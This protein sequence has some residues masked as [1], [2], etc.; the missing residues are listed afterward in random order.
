MSTATSSPLS[1]AILQHPGV[2][3]LAAAVLYAFFRFRDTAIGT[4]RRPDLPSPPTVPLLGHALSF[5]GWMPR[6]SEYLVQM[7]EI[8]GDV[9]RISLPGINFIVTRRIE[10]IEYAQSNQGNFTNFI[11]GEK[12]QRGPMRDILGG[13]I[14]ASDGHQWVVQ[15]KA[16]SHIFS[17]RSFETIIQ[18]NV[19]SH[20][21][22]LIDVLRQAADGQRVVTLNKLFF[23]LTFDAFV[24]MGF[25]VEMN[26]LRSET[27]PAFQTAFDEA[28]EHIVWRSVTQGWP[29]FEKLNGSGARHKRNAQTI[30]EFA[31]GVVDRRAAEAQKNGE[32]GGVP[33]E[34]DL[35]A[36]FAAIRDEKGEPLSR[37]ELR[38]AI[39]NLIIAGRDTTACVL[40]INEHVADVSTARLSAGC[41]ST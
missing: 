16:A 41:S 28:Q 3:L 26:S 14:F 5:L 34:S 4:K 30:D 31:Y 12:L 20:T 21:E 23:A 13:G 39:L 15:R 29:L 18:D 40:K 2:V 24:N 10:D 32:A 19:V 33:K 8:Y 11:K 6:L 25:G 27:P 7:H 22:T 35:L 1:Q 38:D 9:F 36:L 17:K 37:K